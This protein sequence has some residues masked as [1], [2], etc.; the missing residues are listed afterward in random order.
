MPLPLSE[1]SRA[2]RSA[3]QGQRA[4]EERADARAFRMAFLGQYRQLPPPLPP[5]TVYIAPNQNRP[6]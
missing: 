6:R 5:A 4:T 2:I 1:R 3:R